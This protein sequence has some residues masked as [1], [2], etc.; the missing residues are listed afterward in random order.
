MC[1]IVGYYNKKTTDADLEVLKKV[2]IESRIRGKHASGVAWFDGNKIQSII[3][4]IPIDTLVEEINF[5]KLLYNSTK[6]SI[7]AHS[8]Y[9]TSDIE[10]N[11]PIVSDKLAVVHN[12]V[13]TQEPYETWE[14]NYGYKCVGKNDSELILRAIENGDN[15]IDK[16]PDASIASIVLDDSGNLES[17]R[18]PRRPMW[19]G[20][21]GEGLVTASTYD[22]LKRAGVKDIHKVEVK[23]D[24]QKRDKRVW[25]L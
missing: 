19:I 6:I 10:F 16:F 5:N 2:M 17:F 22:I 4:P 20:V 1:G 8:R 9:C 21:I 25:K 18:N 14:K 24:L 3:K 13:I 12:G 15:P 23:N 11:Q 7:I